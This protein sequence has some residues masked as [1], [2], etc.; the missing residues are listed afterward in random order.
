[1]ETHGLV[2]VEEGDRVLV[3]D[4]VRARGE[5]GGGLE[6]GEVIHEEGLGDL[7]PLAKA[8]ENVEVGSEGPV[9]VGVVVEQAPEES[10][11]SIFLGLLT[12]SGWVF[13]E[14]SGLSRLPTNHL[15]T[16]TSY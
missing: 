14:A 2:S 13:I 11:G 16:E 15:H 6:T 8:P 9:E 10:G 4:V 3:F 5:G 12:L 1:M 7:F